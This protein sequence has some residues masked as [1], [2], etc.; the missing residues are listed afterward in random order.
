MSKKLK[1]ILSLILLYGTIIL[2]VGYLNVTFI[3]YINSIEL[4]SLLKFIIIIYVECVVLYFYYRCFVNIHRTVIK[5]KDL[6][7]K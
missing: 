6:F 5:H 7:L 1:A 4:Y 3:K 2:I